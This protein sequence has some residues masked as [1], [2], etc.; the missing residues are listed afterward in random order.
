MKADLHTHT[1]Y[2]DGILS[3]DELLTKASS[4]GMKAIAITDHDTIDGAVEGSRIAG[5]HNIE[6]IIG[7][8]FSCY[9]NEKEYHILGYNLDPDNQNLQI[10]LKNYRNV[11]H[12][13]AKNIHKKLDEFGYKID[14]QDIL[15]IAGAAPITRPHIA[16]ALVKNGLIPTMKEAFI[17]LIGDGCPA[18]QPK[19]LFSVKNCISLINNSGGLAVIAHPRN[20]I[21]PNTLYTFI[22]QGLDGIEVYHP[23]HSQEQVKYYHYVASQYWLLETGGSDFHGNREYDETNFGNF[24]VD[25]NIV[26]SIKYLATNKY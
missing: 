14:F 2:S 15:D 22:E 18:Y 4:F 9:E 23:S 21:D 11:R 7:C 24:T 12:F 5:K 8:E 25:Y 10:H 19:A 6:V 1:Y 17:K 16:Q 26:E 13:R 3:P 20:Y